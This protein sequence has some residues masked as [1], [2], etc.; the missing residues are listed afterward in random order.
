MALQVD[1][2]G[3]TQVYFGG[4]GVLNAVVTDTET[5][6]TPAGLQYAWTAAEGSF[7]GATNG[8]SVT[9]HADFTGSTGQT[10]EI[11][12][13]VTLP[14]NPNPTVSAP[15]LTAMDE[16][17]ITGQLVNMLV[18]AELSGSEL[19]D[20]TSSTAID[21]DSDTLID[22]DMR[23][24]R[25]RWTGSSLILNKASGG[26]LF[27]SWWNG[28]RRDAYSV[29]FII[30]DGTVVE[31]LGTWIALGSGIG[32]NFMRWDVP[33]TETDIRDVLDTIA[34]E[35]LF[36]FGIADTGSIGLPAETASADATVNVRYN[37]P[38]V[39]SITAPQKVNPGDT[40]SVSVTAVDPEGRNVTVQWEATGGTIDNPT[41]L[42]PNFTAP[43]TSGPV[44]LTCTARDADGVEGSN[45]HVI[46]INSPPTV[47]ITAPSQLEVGQDGNISIA[48]SDPNNDTVT[49][50][51]ETSAGSIDDPTALNTTITA[52]ATPQTI[53][54]TCTAT[55]ADG[56]QTIETAQITIVPNQP[57]TL[58]IT[59]PNTLE[60][61][62]IGN[63]RAV[64]GDPIGE[65]VT[66]LWEA[67]DGVIGN[68]AALETTIIGNQPGQIN[69]I[70]T[71][72]D[73]RGATTTATA[74]ITVRQP[75]R[76][77]TVTLNVP[78]QAEPGQTINIEAIVDDLDG[79]DTEG[80]WR[81]PKGRIS[82]PENAST[83]FTTPLE[84][85]IVPITYE[86]MDD[87]GAT[88]TATTYITVGDLKA[89]IYTPAVRIEI[90]G[91]DVTDRRIPRDGLVVGKSLDY[92][93]L[94]TFR[95]SGISFNLDNEDGAFDYNNPNNF[96]VTEGLPAHGRGA[97]VLVRIG[98][99]KDQLIP[100]FAGQI[101]Q[102]ITSLRDTKARINARDLSILLREGF[103]ENFGQT[104]SRTITDFP[105]A[106]ADYDQYNRVFYFPIWGLPISPGSVNITIRSGGT[107]IPIN[108]VDTIAT[109]G[110]LSNRNA[111]ID[112]S[113]GLLR[114][115]APPID[116]ADTIINATW[117]QDF[118]HKRP[119]SLIR[120]LLENAG[121]HTKLGMSSENAAFAI[122][123]ALMRHPE[124]GVFSSHGHP[125]FE[126]EGLTKWIK[127]D[128]ARK[129]VFMVQ[130]TRLLEYD[131]PNDT[132]TELTTLP[133]DTTIAEI[134]PGDYGERITN[135][136]IVLMPSTYRFDLAGTTYNYPKLIYGLAID[137]TNMYVIEEARRQHYY[138]HSATT[139]TFWTIQGF[140]RESGLPDSN[141]RVGAGAYNG[142]GDFQDNYTYAIDVFDNKIYFIGTRDVD[143]SQYQQTNIAAVK[144]I[145]ISTKTQI[146]GFDII[147]GT[148]TTLFHHIA[149]SSTRV[150][151]GRNNSRE[152]RFFDH[153]G[154]EMTNEKFQANEI[155]DGL[156]VNASYI[157]V[158]N[159]TAGTVTVYRHNGTYVANY[160][161]PLENNS[162][163]AIAVN[164]V[165]LYVQPNSGSSGVAQVT[166]ETY[167]LA[168]TVN[169]QG[170]VPIQFDTDDFNN[171]FILATNTLK[172]DITRDSTFNRNRLYKYIK[173]S[174]TISTILS[175]DKGQPQ[176]AHPYDFI[177]AID[178]LV[179]NRKNFRVVKR[180]NKTLIFYRRVETSQSS[181]A[182]YN[183][184][185]DV[186]TNVRT[187]AHTG[188]DNHGLPYSMDFWVDERADGIYIYSFVVRYTLSGN[189]F[190]SA[191]LK[192]FR[193]RVEPTAAETEIYTE[194]FSNTSA[195][196]QYP[197]S[198]SDVLL[199]NDRS[200][201]Y[202]V[203]EYYSESTTEAGKAEL[204]EVAKSGSGSRTV[205]KTYNN[206]LL[207]A[208]SP[209]KLG[210]RYFYLEGQWVRLTSDDDAVPDKNYYPN[211]GGH[212]IE[213]E[214]NG[215]ITDHGIIWQSASK[216]DSPD[217]EDTIYDGWGLHNAII[218][219][220]IADE[221]DNLHFV[222]GFGMPYRIGNN[223]PLASQSDPVPFSDNFVWIQW[224][225]DLS[226]KIPSFPTSGRRGWELIQQLAQLMFWEIGFG[227]AMGRVD[228]LQAAHSNISDWST[229]ASFFFR[230][231]TILPA[232]L[233][234]A[235]TT[236]GNP[237][238]I[239]LN[240]SGLPAEIAE[241]PVPPAGERYAV[242]VDKEMFTYTGVNPD[243]QGRVLTGVVRA[244]NGSAAAAHSIDAAVYFV[245]YFATGEQGSTLVSI[246][247]R[248]LDFVNLKN[249][250][251]VGFGDAIYP[252]KNQ[253]SID[254]NELKTFNLGTSQP[255][256]SRQDQAW[257]EL[258]G[259]TYLDELSDLKEVLQF[260][261]VFSPTLQPGQLVVLYQ[262][263]RVRIEF[264]LFKLV[265]VQH[266][267]HPRWQTSVTPLEI[268]PEG[269]PARWLT[270][271]RQL[272]NFNQSANLD[273]KG[274]VGGTQPIQIE[275]TGL[276]SGFSIN[277]GVISGSSNTAGEHTISLTATN[278]DGEETTNFEILIG[279]PR[280]PSIPQQ[281]ITETDYFI[282]D[283]SSYAPEGLAPITYAL[284]GS[285]PSWASRSGD[286]ILGQPPNESSDQTYIIP[287]V[288]TNEIGTSTVY[289]IVRVEDTI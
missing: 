200:K 205:P 243:S 48:V 189:N 68:P 79:D 183:E 74:T 230:P 100:V 9:Y 258:I 96:F 245:D 248:S 16:L 220:M 73:A 156:A 231:R 203:L 35:Q 169:Y 66:I 151:V 27:R 190:S 15:S 32:G 277:N 260:T 161:I 239:E 227:P 160:D 46:V 217:P 192:I 13:E 146:S 288:A 36:L 1:I 14:G 26:A 23:V 42:N 128:N 85:G 199:A 164:D 270:V 88:T 267:T 204:C 50:F 133:Q 103:I 104:L 221:R 193:K 43:P 216:L 141:A 166:I 12:C 249:D 214:S 6:Q 10:V 95:S 237:T 137:P 251:N 259:D 206:P 92:P 19:F 51:L 41:S 278:R 87:M 210:S 188:T 58:N 274:Y 172:G 65:A 196:D 144:I 282:F 154:N 250:I 157:Y 140:N 223:L 54:V 240:D 181:I 29:F 254:E 4:Q 235:I 155:V 67:P 11:A 264:K 108:I 145:D 99:S 247:N 173:S 94:L 132:Y 159:N 276:P 179:D 281:D 102:V 197:V 236:S 266:H 178:P 279:E 56:L 116:G 105:G 111:E 142:A 107:D 139:S 101:N 269:V 82:N 241:Y 80:E 97:K 195:E 91:V 110:V 53:T 209:V 211:G 257:A 121:L 284:G 33:S 170:F 238:T 182:Y 232:K 86:A 201:F 234:T 84:A 7:V 126:R 226:T 153:D 125:N 49:V 149:V 229:N 289:I 21:A 123:Q 114:F 228:A 135:E 5:G 71:A 253:R 44:T 89:N 184:T 129:K 202:F 117:K 3:I 47:V 131:E 34:T 69:I 24:N 225:Q 185:D 255:L 158:L 106:N 218:S 287:I 77:P 143:P 22:T 25:L 208:R 52:P 118:R 273:L 61:G 168:Q 174:N 134:P 272:L 222:A 90:E 256:L 263:N 31:L 93:E 30:N 64:T 242:I 138:G 112:Y 176:L 150:I 59:V 175:P 28:D 109:D 275:A 207:G 60:I 165:R 180:N 212:L 63:L 119:D 286:Y 271:P 246:Q 136:D 8:A 252:T 127:R 62:Q 124:K 186:I 177:T 215:D 40:V 122:E 261:L 39:V 285:A 152:L 187:E 167:S 38:P 57:P 2:S 115:E 45:T 233:R 83:T 75:N 163:T 78:A 194:T 219:N 224:G 268:I 120:L 98:L 147:G 262:L 280:W 198:V 148:N 244:Q 70:C 81:A 72:T 18:T 171:F 76:P 283:F 265:Q 55:D 162:Y 130:G 20:R 37:A 213:I 113:R 17:G 191:T